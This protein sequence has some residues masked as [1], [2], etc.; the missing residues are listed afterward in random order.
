MGLLYEQQPKRKVFVLALCPVMVA[1][2]DICLAGQEVPVIIFVVV[3]A[4]KTS[5]S[6][7]HRTIL[8]VD[9]VLWAK[10]VSGVCVCVCVCVCCLSRLLDTCVFITQISQVTPLDAWPHCVHCSMA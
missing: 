4:T 6:G 7:T 10:V 8:F 9:P 2:G 5:G 3:R 1:T